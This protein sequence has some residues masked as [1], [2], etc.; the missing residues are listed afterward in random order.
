MDNRLK[1]KGSNEIMHDIP[2]AP[3]R[4]QHSG[5]WKNAA[6]IV[7]YVLCVIPALVFPSAPLAHG[8]VALLM[9][10]DGPN[11]RPSD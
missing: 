4:N 2:P 8:W 9:S 5:A 1:T 10:P 6:F 3:K 11:H 7:L